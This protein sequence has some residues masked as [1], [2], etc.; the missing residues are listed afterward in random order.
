MRIDY[1]CLLNVKLKIVTVGILKHE[2]SLVLIEE[3]IKTSL[4]H[5]HLF[6]EFSEVSMIGAK[7]RPV[8][9]IN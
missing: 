6:E 3:Y 7:D 9:P 5:Y 1:R 4:S 8:K 2:L